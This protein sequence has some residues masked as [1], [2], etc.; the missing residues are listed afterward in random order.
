MLIT[1]LIAHA[2][3]K[4]GDETPPAP[5]PTPLMTLQFTHDFVNPKLG[6]IA[7]ISTMEGTLLA[8][9]GFTGNSTIVLYPKPGVTVP[10]RF[11]V[12]VATWEP[13]MHNFTISLRSWMYIAPSTWQFMGD[14][15]DTIGSCKVT[16][17]NLP[18]HTGP[19]LFANAG[20]SNSTFTTDNRTNL[21]YLQPDDL[22]IKANTSNGPFY[23]WQRTIAPGGNY[24]VD[25]AMAVPAETQTIALPGSAVYHEAALSG[26]RHYLSQSAPPTKTDEIFGDG[27]PASAVV[28]SYPPQTYTAFATDL[29]YID[30]WNSGLSWR[31][32][33]YGAIPEAFRKTDATVVVA[34]PRQPAGLTLSTTGT[35]TA[36]VATWR[37]QST[38]NQTF[39]WTVTGPDT[40]T[41]IDLPVLPPSILQMFPV[42]RLD[43]LSYYQTE[44][45]HFAD[46]TSYETLLNQLYNAENPLPINSMEYS[47]VIRKP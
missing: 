40:V 45:F 38:I 10:S 19:V 26:Y 8:D 36:T 2:G 28:V 47:T 6:A 24:T 11:M 14:R 18:P 12:T 23:Q 13:D 21:I 15:R 29:L 25:M 35:F 34:S 43:S 16:L 7:F 30:D 44:L 9:T 3:C 32:H 20:Y 42:L 37:F 1:I 5:A 41:R 46:A 22:Y 27:N 33:M 4:K 39:R 17:N 31:Y